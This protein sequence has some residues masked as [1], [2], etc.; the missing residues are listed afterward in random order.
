MLACDEECVDGGRGH[1]TNDRRCIEQRVGDVVLRPLAK[2]LSS[3]TSEKR[4]SCPNYFAD[5]R[6][7]AVRGAPEATQRAST[8]QLRVVTMSPT[9]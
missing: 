2:T 6:K 3:P 4:A 7:E 5:V 9:G 8:A 1:S